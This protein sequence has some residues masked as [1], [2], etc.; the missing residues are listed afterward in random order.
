MNAKPCCIILSCFPLVTLVHSMVMR[1]QNAA[2]EFYYGSTQTSFTVYQDESIT[3]AAS[4]LGYPVPTQQWRKNGVNI[5]GATGG[6]LEKSNVQ[7]SDAGNYDAVATN[8]VG[9][10]TSLTMT[11]TVLPPNATI[12]SQPR[13]LSVNEGDSPTF[14]VVA[15]GPR[16]TYQW[17]KDG[18]AL[19]G[20]TRAD[21]TLPAVNTGAAGSYSVVV[22]APGNVVESTPARLTVQPPATRITIPPAAAH[23]RPGETI[24]LEVS[25]TGRDLLYQWK[26]DGRELAGATDRRLTLAEATS[27]DMGFYSVVVS[28]V[29][30]AEGSTVAI[31]TVAAAGGSR[32][33]NASTRAYVPAGGTLTPGFVLRGYGTKEILLRAV[34]PTLGTMGVTTPLSDPRLEL[35][36]AG[37]TQITASNEDWGGGI[38]F[39]QGCRRADRPGGEWRRRVQHAHRVH[40]G[41]FFR[42]RAG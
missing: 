15:T 12:T 36:A 5:P 20:A 42:G 2:P 31:V 6:S 19:A 16:L 41:G 10:A 27:R 7:Y 13:A 35:I 24:T 3:L 22:T 8:S 39:L 28:G 9:R 32:L 26:K 30:G 29:R 11:L 23:V 25:A 33:V 1:P 34:G 40:G 38:A 17:M 14:R 18:V 21:L 4:A 37:T